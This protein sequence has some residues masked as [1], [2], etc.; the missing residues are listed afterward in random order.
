MPLTMIKTGETVRVERVGGLED[1]KRFLNNLGFTDGADVTVVNEID[2]NMIVKVRDA[3]VAINTDMAKK[4][5]V[6]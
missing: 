6:S 1:T 2:G 3:R 4:I 5:M